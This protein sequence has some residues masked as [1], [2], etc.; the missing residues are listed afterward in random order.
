LI[1]YPIAIVNEKAYEDKLVQASLAKIINAIYEQDFLDCSFGFRPK[2]SCHDALKILNYIVNKPEI[3]Y[4]VDADI[5]E[6]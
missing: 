2:R 5:R 4:I 3:N 6:L 1:N